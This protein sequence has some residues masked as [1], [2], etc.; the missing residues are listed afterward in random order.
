MANDAAEARGVL[1]AEGRGEVPG[2]G[3]LDRERGLGPGIAKVEEPLDADLALQA[4]LRREN[5]V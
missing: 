1:R 4:A 3:L 2:S 5:V